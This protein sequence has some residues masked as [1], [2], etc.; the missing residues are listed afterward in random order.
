MGGLTRGHEVLAILKW[1]R[2]CKKSF[3]RGSAKVLDT[4]L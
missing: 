4:S 3:E 1:E 2:G